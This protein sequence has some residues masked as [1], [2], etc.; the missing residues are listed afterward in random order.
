MHNYDPKFV[1]LQRRKNEVLEYLYADGNECRLIPHGEL[2][3]PPGPAFNEILHHTTWA[4]GIEVPKNIYGELVTIFSRCDGEVSIESHII[5]LYVMLTYSYMI[6][7]HI[8]SLVIC[9]PPTT[10]LN[11]QA[12]VF[13]HLCFNG[14]LVGLYDRA[15]T[16]AQITSVS[17]PTLVFTGIPYLSPL[18][19]RK[20]VSESQS[21]NSK[22]WNKGRITE[23]R[24][25]YSPRISMVHALSDVLLKHSTFPVTIAL[26]VEDPRTIKTRQLPE[27]M[28]QFFS[29]LGEKEWRLLM[30]THLSVKN[31]Y[32]V[33]LVAILSLLCEREM[34]NKEIG[35]EINR[36]ISNQIGLQ[37]GMFNDEYY[38]FSAVETLLS[39][40]SDGRN[41]PL[42]T[43][44]VTKFI[45][46]NY[47]VT[48]S[49]KV[50][51]N[52]LDEYH[53]LEDFKPRSRRFINAEGKEEK[54]DSHQPARRCLWIKR[55]EFTYVFKNKYG[56]PYEHT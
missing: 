20:F 18:V 54:R 31:S 3:S 25:T 36:Y 2:V 37:S 9:I 5:A 52:I 8:P 46:E 44:G 15:E 14:Y 40:N 21:C 56:E 13:T 42:L 24:S 16:L 55:D 7:E 35:D 19:K 49:D 50:C 1:I 39:M 45:K 23:P 17:A 29:E 12:D 48:I 4:E 34:L 51:F 43:M 30:S 38:V 6:F 10:D 11:L 32:Y 33:P 27:K 41:L 47:G 26:R 28:M 22:Y 53:V